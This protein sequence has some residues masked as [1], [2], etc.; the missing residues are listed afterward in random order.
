MDLSKT[1]DILDHKI[2][3]PKLEYYD[4]SGV[5]HKHMDSYLTNRKKYVEINDTT[6]NTLILITGVRQGSILGPLLVIIYINDIAHASTLFGFIIYVEDITLEIVF[7]NKYN[8]NIYRAC[9]CK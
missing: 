4:I 6:S 1:F 7:N 2:S 9:K 5:A 8:M 3:L